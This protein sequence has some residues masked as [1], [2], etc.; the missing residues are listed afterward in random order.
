M[1]EL[2]SVAAKRTGTFIGALLLT[3]AFTAPAFAEIEIVTVTTERKVENIQTTPVA[4]TAL[5]G[6]DLKTKQVNSFRDL[7]FHVPSVT[8]TKSNFGGAQFQIRGI[9]TQFGLGAAVAQNENDVYLEAPNL[10]T[11]QYYD[12]DRVEVARGPQSTS[13]GRAAT[14]GA[15]NVITSK[16][17]LDEFAA[18]GSLDYGTY[19]TFKPEVMVNI[20]IIEGELGVRFAALGVFHDGYEKNLY[21]GPQIYPGAPVHNKI[22]G[23]G[24]ASGR[25]S[26]RWE[27]SADTTVDFIGEYGFENDNR[28][29]GDKQMCHRD[30]SGVI[31]CLPD[32]LG[33][34]P[35]N[36]LSTLGATLG[37]KQGITA[38]LNTSFGADFATQAQPAG[39]IQG[40]FQLAGNGGP[41]DPAG[42]AGAAYLGVMP[43]ALPSTYKGGPSIFPGY[44]YM[45]PQTVN[46]V[47][48]GANG[49]VSHDLLTSNTAFNPV[50]K[51]SG[52]VFMLN[53]SQ[54]ITSWLK[55]SLDAGYSA[56][57][58]FTQQNYNDATPEN[59]STLISNA[60]IGFHALH[61][62]GAN[63][64][65][66]YNTYFSVPGALPISN[67][68]YNGKFG[69]YAGSIDPAHG[70]LTR[71]GYFSAYDEDQFSQREWTGELRLSTNFDGPLNFTTGVFYMSYDGRNQYWVAS[72]GLDWESM[73]V[74]AFAGDG[75]KTP[76]MLAST[77][78]DGEY[79]RGAVQSRSAFLEAT[80]DIIPDELRL[81]VGGRYNDDRSS[82]L[83]TQ[84]AVGG[85]LLANGFTPVGTPSCT[86]NG[87]VAAPG[88][89][90]WPG[91]F[92]LPTGVTTKP[93]SVTDEW[94]GRI[95]LTWTPHLSW[96][97]QT[98]VY[99]TVSR[100]ELAGGVNKAQGTATLVVPSVY[101]PA[102]VDAIEVGTKNTLLDGS[103]QANLTAW[104]YNYE[105]YQVGIIANRAALTYNIP[106]H[107][108]GLE[109]EFVWQPDD[110]LVF[111]MTL[112]L[113]RSQAGNAYAV[114]Q[115]NPTGGVANSILIKD[116]ING[117]LCVIVPIKPG[118]VGHTPGESNPAYHVNN[119]YLPN[120]GNAAIDAPYGVPL[121]NYGVCQ[122]GSYATN[123]MGGIDVTSTPI[124]NALIAAGFDYATATNPVTGAL[125]TLPAG[126]N[127][128]TGRGVLADGTGN[129]VNLHGNKLPQVPNAQVGFGAQYTFHFNEYTLVPRLDYYWQSSMEARVN[130]DPGSDYIG[131]WD[132]LNGQ[133]QLNAPDDK[134]YARVFATNI[135][136]KHNPTGVYLTDPTSA[137][138]TN[139]FAEDPRVVG[140]SVGANW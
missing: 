41:G 23:Q 51:G 113:T 4:V 52:N 62:A 136:D 119:F 46:G 132:T 121:V 91:T 135:F 105:N 112:S 2:R 101:S 87:G 1:P 31:G 89:V 37:S 61:D 43:T 134:W 102:T 10:V 128:P 28:V 118:A 5:S 116:M 96:T 48:T 120:G 39:N 42:P 66:A 100:G 60:V 98:L 78:Y 55:G 16:P 65:G 97:D 30:P 57:Y 17:N 21:S 83:T 124:R 35:I 18:R 110:D 82:A 99:G 123:A 36:V 20:P 74:G 70:I 38:L 75:T 68:Y 50:Y 140:I 27:P 58:Q 59:V 12:V 33:F 14:G 56:G 138:F 104:Y 95:N 79:R 139:V 127:D 76:L 34:D 40:I 85:L 111:N 13:Y 108:Y 71:T 44:S 93:N 8:Y 49:V 86:A 114:D 137:L 3:T 47:G 25:F 54:T 94:T 126:S 103:L 69:S 15:V 53:W 11:G 117:S 63:A 7:Q 72:N 26:V 131:A 90:G 115:R 92:R 6:A 9:T 29:R 133:I 22:N 45:L 81:I 129:A 64:G 32:R 107:L 80:Y 125:R 109:G 122:P 19:N 73:V 88:C 77:S 24:T 67:T 84:I 130:N 106:A